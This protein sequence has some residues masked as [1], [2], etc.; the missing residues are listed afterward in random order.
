MEIIKSGKLKTRKNNNLI[1]KYN[2]F[3]VNETK[4]AKYIDFKNSEF[5]LGKISD[6]RDPESRKPVSIESYEQFVTLKN[7]LRNTK[8]QQHIRCNKIAFDLSSINDDMFRIM[9]V[10]N[11]GGYFVSEKLRNAILEMKFSGMEFKE[12][13]EI[14]KV[15]Y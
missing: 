9:N 15:N 1:Q 10:P 13:S 7:S 5:L 2:L 6:W 8:D 11:V 12:M 3:F 14:E 4:E